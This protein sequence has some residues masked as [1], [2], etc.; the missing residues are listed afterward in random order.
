MPKQ[1]KYKILCNIGRKELI[2]N[3]I[4]ENIKS[5]TKRLIKQSLLRTR[6]NIRKSRFLTHTAR[7][8]RDTLLPGYGVINLYDHSRFAPTISEYLKQVEQQKK[9]KKRPLISLV[10]PTY[11]TPIPYLEACIES[12]IVQSYDNW[13]LCIADDASPNKEVV[14]L[15]KQYTK[16][17]KR[18]KLVVRDKNGHI[19][20]ATNSALNIASG[21]FIAL[22][23]HDDILWPNA[24]YEVVHVINNYPEVDFIYS[25]EDK[26]DKTGI[27][28][29]YPFFKPD[30][31]PEFLESCN[32][33]TH[34]A[35][36]RL[37]LVREVKGFRKG[38]EGA[39]DWDLFIRVA[40]KTNRI[41]HIPKILYSWRIHEESTASN[42]DAKPYVYD[43]QRKLLSDHIDRQVVKGIV[44]Q[45]IITQHA[46]IE[47]YIHG[48]PKVSII[49]A[50]GTKDQQ[51]KCIRSLLRHTSYKNVEVIVCNASGKLPRKIL[52]NN[53]KY[54]IVKIPNNSSL[55]LSYNQSAE[56]AEGSFLV[57]VD[58]ATIIQTPRWLELMLGD[59]Q[60][61]DIGV[62]GGKTVNRDG[63]RF[64]RAGVGVGIYGNF[65][66]LL[67]W[68]PIDEVH[69]LRG[70]YGQS[71][72]NVAAVDSG[73]VGMTKDNFIK[74]GGFDDTIDD[75]F[76]VDACLK[77]L[78]DLKR[79]VYNP[80]I[81]SSDQLN[82]TTGQIDSYRSRAS[83]EIF[84]K[85]WTE[86]ITSDPYLNPAFTRTNA[87]LEVK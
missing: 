52:G 46:S 41:V 37:S 84:Q 40:E 58:S 67:E 29:S 59:M 5:I 81:T 65:A 26:V 28:H 17:D 21:E 50:G 33:I 74:I 18:I 78:R 24:L 34:F 3:M 39:Q 70:L 32:Y 77:L 4:S 35:C 57:F 85:R 80:F 86:Y 72:R 82:R 79:N 16:Q 19:S 36:L 44:K 87:Q 49:V 55:A 48:S 7:T 53:I 71:R 43:A 13:E 30:W 2:L 23:D 54:K 62:V 83:I 15:I 68:M 61:K 76:V 14:A 1:N 73:C 11:N 27:I 75:M 20:E 63:D 60:R 69:Y 66:S 51:N 45:S 25:D 64:L 38:Y 31:S 8:I 10:M 9:I 6:K 22:I 47:Y 42:T 56:Q 12:V